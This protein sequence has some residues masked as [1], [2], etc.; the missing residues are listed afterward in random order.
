MLQDFIG[1]FLCGEKFTMG[2]IMMAP[3][4][5]RMCALEHYRGFVIPDTEAYKNWKEWKTN[6][7]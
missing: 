2:D 3:F 1:P 7:L 4:F 5:H 6:V